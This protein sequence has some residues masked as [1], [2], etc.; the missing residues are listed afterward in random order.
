MWSH[1][2]VVASLLL[3]LKVDGTATIAPLSAAMGSDVAAMS[4][5]LSSVMW[6]S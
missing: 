3:A 1:F 5:S 2:D 6:R 4:R